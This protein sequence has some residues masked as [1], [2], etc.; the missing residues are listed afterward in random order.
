MKDL[1]EFDDIKK[2][3]DKKV[4]PIV[5]WFSQDEGHYS[6]VVGLDDQKIY[7]RDPELTR[8][9]ELKRENFKRVWFD[10]PDDFIKTRSDL[11]IRRLI[12][13]YK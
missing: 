10:F 4:P 13:I 6:V 8:R 3:L 7:L 11:I 2:W 12:A 1:A 5:D 9:R